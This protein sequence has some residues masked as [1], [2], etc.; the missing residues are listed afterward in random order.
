[1]VA[2]KLKMRMQLVDLLVHEYTSRHCLQ[3]LGD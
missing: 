2:A 1:M 3:E